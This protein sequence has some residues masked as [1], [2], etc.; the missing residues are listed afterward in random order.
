MASPQ[1]VELVPRATRRVIVEP[2]ERLALTVEANRPPYPPTSARLAC[3]VPSFRWTDG[4]GQDRA[5]IEAR[6]FW[7]PSRRSLACRALRWSTCPSTCGHFSRVLSSWVR[8]FSK[9]LVKFRHVRPTSAPERVFPLPGQPRS[10]LNAAAVGKGLDGL[11]R[12]RGGNQLL[13]APAEGT[14]R[15]RRRRFG[16][17]LGLDQR[18]S[19][20]GKV[21]TVGCAA[22]ALMVWRGPGSHGDMPE[23]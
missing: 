6:A 22:L 3:Q 19:A 2:A 11:A 12:S 9:S 21:V 7:Y 13:A 4:R 15:P 10:R 18:L 8:E 5:V 17:D 16:E 14:A 1:V 23:A 20:H